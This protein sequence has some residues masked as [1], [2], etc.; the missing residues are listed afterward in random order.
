MRAAD[1]DFSPYGITPS[2]SLLVSV[3]ANGENAVHPS[4]W[5]SG[6]VVTT[7]KCSILEPSNPLLHMAETLKAVRL[8]APAGLQ[9]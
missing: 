1:H 6:T 5:Y 7:V 3:P 4:Q 9:V 2:V 8:H